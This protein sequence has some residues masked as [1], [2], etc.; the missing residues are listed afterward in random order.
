MGHLWSTRRI[1]DRRK[2]LDKITH[3]HTYVYTQLRLKQVK[4][5]DFAVLIPLENISMEMTTHANT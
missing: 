3:M 1:R 4:V 2:K 5:G